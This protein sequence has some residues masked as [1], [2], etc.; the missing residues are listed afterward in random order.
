MGVLR[1]LREFIARHS[2]TPDER[3]GRAIDYSPLA[4]LGTQ[5]RHNYSVTQ[6]I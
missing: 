5:V 6:T 3:T 2:F 4:V 1:L